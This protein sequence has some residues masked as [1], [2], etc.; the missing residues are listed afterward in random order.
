MP[1]Y[2]T[3]QPTADPSIVIE[4][5]GDDPEPQHGNQGFVRYQHQV[6]GPRGVIG[7]RLFLGGDKITGLADQALL[8]Q[9]D[10]ASGLG[11]HPVQATS[12]LQPTYETGIQN[13]LPAVW[14]SGNDGMSLTK[15]DIKAAT[16]AVLGATLYVVASL[17]AGGVGSTTKTLFSL[18]AGDDVQAA[19]FKYG[20]RDTGGGVWRWGLVGRRLDADTAQTL[21]GPTA[22][23]S[24]WLLHTCVVDWEYSNAAIYLG[25]ALEASTSSWFVDGATSATDPMASG[26]GCRSD[27]L[28]EYW[29]GHIGELLF[30]TRAHDGT[31]RAAIW[32]YLNTKWGLA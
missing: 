12:S 30:Y 17:T 20:Q 27:I 29:I 23:T 6:E 25:T 10:D 24:G 5:R 28:A 19:R 21:T 16:N 1:V 32:D 14:F 11:N 7:L 15:A 3:P 22:T 18:S 9:W 2:S 8:A 13:T 31:E 4:A 26:I